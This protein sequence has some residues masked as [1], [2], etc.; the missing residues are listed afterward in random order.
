MEEKLRTQEESSNDLERRLVTEKEK[1]MTLEAKLKKKKKKVSP[2]K[3]S[4][5]DLKKKLCS[6]KVL[7]KF[8]VVR[9]EKVERE[10]ANLE[11]SIKAMIDSASK[12]TIDR[13]MDY[14]LFQS[15]VS[16]AATKSYFIAFEDCWSKA[17][18]LFSNWD[19]ISLTIDM[20]EETKEG[21]LQEEQPGDVEADQPVEL[22][23]TITSPKEHIE[24]TKTQRIEES[25]VNLEAME[26]AIVPTEEANVLAP[27]EP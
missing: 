6:A 22:A 11:R 16:E 7:L 10:K 18:N 8:T 24:P 12:K 2:L 13:Y 17:A 19:L 1:T 25:V 21:E 15:E 27:G 20:G 4:G 5:A 23:P 26:L 14:D 9:A 3:S